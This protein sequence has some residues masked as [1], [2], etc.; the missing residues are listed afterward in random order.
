MATNAA[1]SEL[2]KRQ[3]HHRD[4]AAAADPQQTPA[5]SE[6]TGL[7]TPADLDP[8]R[9]DAKPQ[10]MYG[11]TPDGTRMFKQSHPVGC[12]LLSVG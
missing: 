5:S 8:D 6:H 1:P 12:Q 3:Q 9:A 10:K 11:R 2:R 7:S 4:D